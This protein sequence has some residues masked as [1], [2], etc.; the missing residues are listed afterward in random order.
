MKLIQ[1]ER[2]KSYRMKMDHEMFKFFYKKNKVKFEDFFSKPKNCF[3]LKPKKLIQKVNRKK[4]LK[5]IKKTK[6]LRVS[7]D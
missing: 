3:S 7:I 4:L 6:K 1:S 2:P 5:K